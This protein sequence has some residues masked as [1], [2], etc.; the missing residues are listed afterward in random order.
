MDLLL[1]MPTIGIAAEARYGMAGGGVGERELKGIGV[2]DISTV[3]SELESGFVRVRNFVLSS[4]LCL[5]H[6]LTII[7]LV[8]NRL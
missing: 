7:Y 5:L 4:T 6:L 2:L 1:S 3:A 8:L